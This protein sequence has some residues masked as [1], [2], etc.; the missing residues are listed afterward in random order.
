MHVKFYIRGLC[1]A[2]MA[3]SML[4]VTGC[5]T[6]NEA[7]GEKLSKSMGDPGPPDPTKAAKIST[8]A[9]S[10][11]PPTMESFSKQMPDAQRAEYPGVKKK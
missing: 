3:V 7:E 10:G 8:P 11:G 4:G 1:L 2:L 6:E 9:P 5:G